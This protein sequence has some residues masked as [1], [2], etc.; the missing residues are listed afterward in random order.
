M[1]SVPTV[2][3]QTASETAEGILKGLGTASSA[4][5]S[6]AR[7]SA[8]YAASYATP[9]NGSYT[10]N[11]LFYLVLYAFILFLVLILVHFT[12]YPVFK[13]TPGAKGLIGV[14][15]SNDSIVYWNTKKQPATLA[16]APLDN[17]T[18]GSYPMI[19]NFSFSVDLFVRRMTDTTAT[20]RV[21]MYKT[22]ANGP[23][24]GTATVTGT[25]SSTTFAADP[26]VTGPTDA[27][28]ANKYMNSKVSMFMYL[29]QTNDLVV[30]FFSG[31]QGTPYSSRQI[32]NIPLYTPFRVTVVVEEKTFTVYINAQ[33]AFQRT[34]PNNILLNTLGSLP[35]TSQRLFAPPSW[36]D[37]PTKT[38]FLQNLQLWPRAISY[39]EVQTAQPALALEADFGMEKESGTSS[40]G[41]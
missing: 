1:S 37:Q 35:T 13:F 40:C 41:A 31:P 2:A 19:N 39:K 10:L 8:S 7:S 25:T 32:K 27:D 14:P 16:Y 12:I 5:S 18:L 4:V 3:G 26:L 15:A 33:Q 9:E 38:I 22:Y 20:T 28:I 34:V 29:T 17:D 30:T 11:V 6:A 24:S 21:I 23:Q 36:A